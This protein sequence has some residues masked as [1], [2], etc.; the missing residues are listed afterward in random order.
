M[1]AIF[2]II[3]L[4]VLAFVLMLVLHACGVVGTVATAPGRVINKT[5]ETDN[6]IGNYEWF[7]DVNAKFDSR[8]AQIKDETKV[9]D[10]VTDPAEHSR[11]QNDLSAMRQSCRDLATKY[12]ANS[13]KANKSIFK[14][15]GLPE[16]LSM[17]DCEA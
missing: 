9:L 17:T 5:L 4:L 11:V 2:S 1:K 15:H 7:Y 8:V 14:S 10:G 12:N 3:G 16:T 6:I 13:E